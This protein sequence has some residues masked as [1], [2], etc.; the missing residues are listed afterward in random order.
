MKNL[1]AYRK[2]T[3]WKNV[4]A[5]LISVTFLVVWLPF[6]RSVF[7]GASYPWGTNYFG[8]FISGNGITPEFLF[9][10]IQLVFY[11]I[12]MYSMYWMR[13]RIVFY[14]LALLWFINSF[15]N[16]LFD[17]AVNGDTL[18]HGETLNV[19]ISL[20]WVVL[21]LSAISL[22][23]IYQVIRE[24]AQSAETAYRWTPKNSMRLLL[25]LGPLPLQ[26]LLLAS[27]EPDGITD[28]VGVI[29]SISQCLLLPFVYKPSIP[30]QV[31]ETA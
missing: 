20:F 6:L 24:D 1:I 13:N 26:A 7:D 23:L 31:T 5:F 15:G 21:P 2:P 3:V 8:F 29:M 30:P 19:H 18:F 14:I 12:L 10:V 22:L 27:G 4:L 25:I 9:V 28:Q 17:I 11:V 16:L